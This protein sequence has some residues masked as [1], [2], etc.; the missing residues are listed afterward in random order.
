MYGLDS[1]DLEWGAVASFREHANK[2]AGGIK[3]GKSLYY[4]SD[5]RRLTTGL[6]SM[7]LVNGVRIHGNIRKRIKLNLKNNSETPDLI[8]QSP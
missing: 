4:V 6:C 5:Y 7:E 2:P 8:L 1:R 3:L